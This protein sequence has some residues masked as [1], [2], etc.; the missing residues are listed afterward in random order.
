MT[1]FDKFIKEKQKDLDD[2]Y[3]KIPKENGLLDIVIEIVEREIE[4]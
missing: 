4:L 3:A 2:L 1:T